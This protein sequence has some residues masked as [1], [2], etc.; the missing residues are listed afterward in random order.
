MR[1]GLSI[2]LSYLPVNRHQT[3]YKEERYEEEE[4]VSRWDCDHVGDLRIEWGVGRNIAAANLERLCRQ[5]PG[6]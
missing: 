1:P 3:V 5:G 2:K 4:I 6:G